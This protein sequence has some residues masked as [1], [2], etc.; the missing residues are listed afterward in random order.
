MNAADPQNGGPSDVGLWDRTKAGDGG[1]FAELYRRHERAVLNHAFRRTG[2][3]Q[4]AEDI[5]SLVFL[6]TWR[7]RDRPSVEVTLLPWLLGVANNIVRHQNRSLRRHRA[8]MDRINS[9]ISEPD[10]SDDVAQRID[11]ERQMAAVREAMSSLTRVEQ[12]TVALCVWAGL[13]YSEAATAMRVPI[14]TVRS[15]LARARTR[16]KTTTA[17][18]APAL[19]AVFAT[20]EVTHD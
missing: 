15:R 5:T 4:Q 18:T 6:E 20:E 17:P 16:L 2:S 9:H 13:S 7:Q 19:K 14:G 10:H 8:A 11:D 12:E 1:A 3:W